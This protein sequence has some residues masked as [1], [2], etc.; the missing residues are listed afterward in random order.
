MKH[1]KKSIL[2]VA[3]AIGAGWLL[4]IALL[5]IGV[6]L[7]KVNWEVALHGYIAT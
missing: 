5:F 1:H 3:G 4:G 6:E 7:E 2:L